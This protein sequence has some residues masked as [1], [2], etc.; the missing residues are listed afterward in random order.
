[1]I[2][3]FL[4]IFIM[5]VNTQEYNMIFSSNTLNLEEI[6]NILEYLGLEAIEKYNYID[7]FNLLNKYQYIRLNFFFQIINYYSN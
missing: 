4:F 1:M 6:F 2:Y 7:K 3:I 5:F